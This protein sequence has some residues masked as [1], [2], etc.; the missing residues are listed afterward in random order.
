MPTLEATVPAAHAEHA[1]EP[2]VFAN[3]PTA[4]LVQLLAPPMFSAAYVP[5][6]HGVHANDEAGAYVPAEH[7]E[8]AAEPA[9]A[10]NKPAAQPAQAPASAA[11]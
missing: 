5:V 8:Q 9:D 4:Q 11:E 3:V 6:L 10:A 7:E 1:T 2:S